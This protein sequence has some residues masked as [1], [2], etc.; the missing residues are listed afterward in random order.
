MPKTNAT[1]CLLF[2]EFLLTLAFVNMVPRTPTVTNILPVQ[3]YSKSSS[4]DG[5]CLQQSDQ[6]NEDSMLTFRH[7]NKVFIEM[8][9]M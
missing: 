9:D 4:T 3:C 1:F 7:S 8:T 6:D 2:N 5:V